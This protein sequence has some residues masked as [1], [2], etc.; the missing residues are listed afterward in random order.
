MGAEHPPGTRCAI[1]GVP[2]DVPAMLTTCFDCGEP[3]HLNPF[4]NRP[5]IDCGDAV[6]GETLGVHFYCQRCLDRLDAEAAGKPPPPEDAAYARA[7]AA[8]GAI[9]GT[10]L[11]LPPHTAPPAAQPAAPAPRPG[12]AP[13]PRRRYRRIDRDTR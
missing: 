1:C 3:Y 6:L 4:S 7:E 13:R 8:I 5:G 12:H 11:P 10:S 2:E 9:H